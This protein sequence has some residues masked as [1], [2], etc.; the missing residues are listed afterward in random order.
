MTWEGVYKPLPEAMSPF[1]FLGLLLFLCAPFF[2]SLR[3]QTTDCLD[4][5]ATASKHSLSLL[6]AK[7]N[8]PTA[9]STFSFFF[10][11]FSF[12]SFFFS[13]CFLF[14]RRHR[15]CHKVWMRF[16]STLSLITTCI[17]DPISSVGSGSLP[18]HNSFKD[19]VKTTKH[20]TP[21]WTN[22][23]RAWK[24]CW[25]PKPG[26]HRRPSSIPSECPA[27]GIRWNLKFKASQS[28][29]DA[30]PSSEAQ[31]SKGQLT[32]RQGQI[33]RTTGACFSL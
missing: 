32:S 1:L 3:F 26:H 27:M 5:F 8:K 21:D 11:S 4:W 9:F 25:D 10:F 12:S 15:F 18:Y 14:S 29:W 33:S 23:S 31:P 22:G 7:V 30:S 16:I 24:T 6:R 19:E 17:C 2:C 13:F 28:K 20:Y